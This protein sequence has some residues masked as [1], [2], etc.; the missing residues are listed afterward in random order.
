MVWI[1]FFIILRTIIVILHDFCRDST[2]RFL[3]LT[4]NL[5][6][7]L[8]MQTRNSFFST[9]PT[10]TKHLLVINF[11]CWLADVVLSSRGL[12][13]TDWFGLYYIDSENFH[14]WQFLTYM[15]M[16]GSFSHMFFNMFALF[17][18]AIPLEQHWGGK[19]FLTYYLITGIGAGVIQEL[20]WWLIYGSN[21]VPAVTIGASGAVFG[22]L[23]AFGW[24][25]PDTRLFVFPIPIPVRARKFVVIYAVIELIVGVTN[26]TGVRLDN[27][28]HFAHLGGLIFGWLLILYWRRN[29]INFA[30]TPSDFR[31]KDWWNRIKSKFVNRKK[32]RNPYK[33]YHYQNPV[34]NDDTDKIAK[35]D[36]DKILDKLRQS[37]YDSLTEEEKSKLFKR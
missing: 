17:M 10:I 15:F 22:I 28:A 6:L 37:G 25:F 8:I 24:L 30:A 35:Q 27:V 4:N 18:F 2:S 36:M 5:E 7:L 14:L 21:P 23:F 9:I 32:E 19:R 31:I 29:D 12:Y 16:H 3:L 33:D 20:V 26:V 11:I 1:C 13:I 34:S